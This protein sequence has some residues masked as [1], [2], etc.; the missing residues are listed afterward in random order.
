MGEIRFGIG[1]TTKCVSELPI[2]VGDHRRNDMQDSA[3][4]ETPRV[5]VRKSPDGGGARTIG[6]PTFSLHAHRRDK[7][8]FVELAGEL[9]LLSAPQLREML[10]EIFTVDLP[11]RLVLDLSDLIYLDST[12]LSV[13]VT[14]HKRASASGIAFCLANPNASVR[15]LLKITALDQIFVIVDEAGPATE[16]DE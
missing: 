15:R 10:V 16:R 5:P 4:A 6:T 11:R 12:G 1:D 9:D 8:S 14:A 13:F 3:P 2:A 7:E